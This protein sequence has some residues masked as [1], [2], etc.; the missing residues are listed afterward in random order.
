MCEI[1]KKRFLLLTLILTLSFVFAGFTLDNFALAGKGINTTAAWAA[2]RGSTRSKASS[3]GFK[4]G[5]FK[6]STPSKPSTSSSSKSSSKSSSGGFKSG[7]FSTTPKT[8]TDTKNNSTS[9]K[10]S[11]TSKKQ[12][13]KYEGSKNTYVP[14][15]IPWSLGRSTR[16]YGKPYNY[17]SFGILK[18]IFKIIMFL[19]VLSIIV[20]IINKNKRK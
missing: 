10:S 15:P 20:N 5:S 19:I 1:R 18:T 3:G 12:N 2:P 8:S 7:S 13:E 9:T 16:S 6:S 11:S 14:I 4:S 17:S